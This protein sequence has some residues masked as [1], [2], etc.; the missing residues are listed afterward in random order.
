MSIQPGDVYWERLPSVAA[1]PEG[2][3]WLEFQS[4]PGLANNTVDVARYVA[5][6]GQRRGPRGEPVIALDSGAGLSK[7]RSDQL[8]IPGALRASMKTVVAR[9]TSS[10][11]TEKPR[12][13]SRS[14]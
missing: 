11:I 1:L 9:D 3:R 14:P 6:L 13:F 5:E 8:P 4:M 2:K 7:M 12:R 10:P